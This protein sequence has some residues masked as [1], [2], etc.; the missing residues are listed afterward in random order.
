MPSEQQQSRAA[1]A[2]TRYCERLRR[3]LG[4]ELD[5]VMLYGSRARGEAIDASDVDVLVIMKRPFDYDELMERTSVSTAEV[6]LEWDV[7]IS[8]IFFTRQDYE[9]KQTPFLM[10]VR[11]EALRL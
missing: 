9:S 8:R 1:E 11:R 7:V 6:S 3:D 10:N 5:S 2:L 4:S